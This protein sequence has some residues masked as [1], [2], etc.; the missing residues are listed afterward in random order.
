MSE[1][2]LVATPGNAIGFAGPRPDG[3]GNVTVDDLVKPVVKLWHPMAKYEI[4]GIKLG[5]YADLNARKSLGDKLSIFILAQKTIVAEIDDDNGGKKTVAFKHLLVAFEGRYN[6]PVEMIFSAG[7]VLEVKRLI[8]S[9][10]S[11]SIEKGGV[12]FYGWL[13]KAESKKLENKKGKYAVPQF[14][15]ARET[16]NEELASLKALYDQHAASFLAAPTHAE[17]EEAD[18][19][20]AAPIALA[21]EE[22]VEEAFG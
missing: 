13:I 22:K 18:A 14:S 5:E 19:V 3:F 8:T 1:Q 12:P 15:V 16:T 2:G 4:D 7:A 20:D 6:F 21:K 17:V 11:N 10:I 9:L